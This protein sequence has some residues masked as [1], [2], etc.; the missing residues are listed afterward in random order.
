MLVALFPA[1]HTFQPLCHRI[2]RLARSRIHIGRMLG[3]TNWPVTARTRFDR[4]SLVIRAAFSAVFI[5][6]MHLDPGQPFLKPREFGPN[7]IF[8]PLCDIVC[9]HYGAVRIELKLHYLAFLSLT[10]PVL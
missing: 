6:H 5:R 10:A 1:Q 4:A 3:D 2:R 8:D 7:L 9:T